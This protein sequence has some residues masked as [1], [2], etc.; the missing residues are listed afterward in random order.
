MIPYQVM[1]SREQ[2]DCNLAS[3]IRSTNFIS[4]TNSIKDINER[5]SKC[6]SSTW[7]LCII[8]NISIAHKDYNCHWITWLRYAV[9]WLSR[10]VCDLKIVIHKTWFTTQLVTFI[11]R[12][13]TD[14]TCCRYC[15]I[16]YV[17]IFNLWEVSN[18]TVEYTLS[19]F[20][21]SFFTQ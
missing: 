5:I 16:S 11:T 8:I 2:I 9:S 7:L 12:W 20:D 21:E 19:I 13:R 18:S 4:S 15:F 14:F 1:V 6:S 17:I 10:Y 3:W